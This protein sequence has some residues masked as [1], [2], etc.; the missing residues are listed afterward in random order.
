[1]IVKNRFSVEES[2]SVIYAFCCPTLSLET[3]FTGMTAPPGMWLSEMVAVYSGLVKWTLLL[4]VPFTVTTRGTVL[5]RAALSSC[6]ACE[7]FMYLLLFLKTDTDLTQRT[8]GAKSI[9]EKN[10][11]EYFQKHAK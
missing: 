11:L 10:A 4:V 9:P 5:E 1:M 8:D 7:R 2:L 6:V 3:A